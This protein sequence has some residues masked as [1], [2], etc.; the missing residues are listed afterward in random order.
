MKKLLVVSLLLALPLFAQSDEAFVAWAKSRMVPVD[1]FRELDPAIQRAKLI[2][3]GE[4]VHDTEEFFAFRLQLL[5][6]LV[7]RHRVTA[8]VLE[9]GLPEAM[10]LNDYVRGRTSTI[11]YDAA[12]PGGYGS[13]E[14]IHKTMEW[15]RAWNLG[16]GRAR[17]VGVYGA[18]FSNRSGSMVPSLDRLLALTVSDDVVKRLVE[19]I[20]PIAVQTS[21]GWW[22]GAADKY[23]ALSPETKG[24]LTR[25]IGLLAERVQHRYQGDATNVATLLQQNEAALRLGMFEPTAPRDIALADNTLRVVR[26]L[27]DDERAVYWAHNAHVQKVPIHGKPLPPGTFIGSGLRFDVV[28]GDAY[29]AIATSYGGPARDD[30]SAPADGSVDAALEKVSTKPFLLVLKDGPAWLSRERTMRFQ[31]GY[32]DVILGDAF[33][34]VAYFNRATAAKHQ[35]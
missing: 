19:S 15:L 5:Q 31:T 32:L 22:K 23:A 20:R 34:A 4:S 24:A 10:A 17:P 3:V 2:G 35:L 28:L 1:Q 27:G 9:S 25:D 11:D 18:D 21:A 29:V 16:D 8:L 30:S 12:L 26:G 33:D 13:L 7:R 14:A 6:D